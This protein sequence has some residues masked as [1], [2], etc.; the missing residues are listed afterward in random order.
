MLGLIYKMS[1]KTSYESLYI[2]ISISTIQRDLINMTKQLKILL[3]L[4]INYN[5]KRIQGPTKNTFLHTV[6]KHDWTRCEHFL[7]KSCL[8]N[9]VS[10]FFT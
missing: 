7:I 3:L 10:Y 1:I 5:L 8:F 9:E 2:L 4:S 6:P